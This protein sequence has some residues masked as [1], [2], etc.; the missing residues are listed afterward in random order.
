MVI[1]SLIEL[2]FVFARFSY[3]SKVAKEKVSEKESG[4]RKENRQDKPLPSLEGKKID[5][6]L[7]HLLLSLSLFLSLS[8]RM[9]VTVAVELQ[10]FP[11]ETPECEVNVC[12][13]DRLVSQYTMF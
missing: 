9:H 3:A 1:V 11:S 7:H 5:Y 13:R 2:D 8:L 4:N 10:F 6:R 12:A